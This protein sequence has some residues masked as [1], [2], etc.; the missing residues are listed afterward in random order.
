MRR[1]T[2]KNLDYWLGKLQGNEQKKENLVKGI[3]IRFV[4]AGNKVLHNTNTFVDNLYGGVVA[5]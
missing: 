1:N 3:K 4:K 2:L 5:Q